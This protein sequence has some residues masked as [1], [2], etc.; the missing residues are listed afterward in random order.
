MKI[1]I[2][3]MQ[4]VINYGSFLQAYALIKSLNSLGHE[5]YFIDI[6]PGKNLYD[7]SSKK[8]INSRIN[9]MFARMDKEI[10]HRIKRRKNK[11]IRDYRF[12]HEFFPILNLSKEKKY[13]SKYDAVVIGSDEVFNC[14]QKSQWGF[15]KTLLGEGLDSEIIISYAASCG[16]TTLEDIT[17][18]GLNEE[19]SYAMKNF[20]AISVRDE[21]TKAF[22]EEMTNVP[23]YEHIDPTL[24]YDFEELTSEDIQENNYILVYAYEDRINDKETIKVI[25]DFARKE[26]K[27]TISAGV[28]QYWCDKRI[29][30]TPFELLSY[31]K[32]AD[33]VVAD[34][35]HGTVFSIKYNK[36]FVS[37]VRDSNKQK[38]TD[39][40]EKFKLTDRIVNK[41][42]QISN[43]L[44]EEIDYTFTN[45]EI[46]NYKK[47]AFEYF[48]KYLF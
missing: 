27:I 11:K 20:R 10:I 33:Y 17:N 8:G 4:R 48:E 44:P 31:F 2:L 3:S 12:Q 34:T 25:K 23:I 37:I 9:Y 6:R 5:T 14:T 45:K 36:K 41:P 7:V 26:G 35:F 38:L 28:C 18:L 22:A 21:N 13:I 15:A 42:E 40:L 1:G 19:I 29:I 32:K 47:T 30:C 16:H 43:K 24:I 39:L 46:D